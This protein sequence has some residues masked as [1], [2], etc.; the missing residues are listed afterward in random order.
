MSGPL[1]TRVPLSQ[2]LRDGFGTGIVEAH[3]V[4]QRA[5]V[6][7]AKHARCV[8]TRLRVLRH[9]AQF[10]KAEPQP[11]PHWYGGRVFVHPGREPDGIGKPQAA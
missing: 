8:I 2:C 3:A 7:G 11:F 1:I 10:G 5:I 6:D 9:A 4:D